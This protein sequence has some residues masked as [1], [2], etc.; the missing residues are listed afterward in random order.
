MNESSNE[1]HTYSIENF[2]TK[3]SPVFFFPFQ[4]TSGS[5]FS[6]PLF[7]LLFLLFCAVV[8]SIAY[9]KIFYNLY[10]YKFSFSLLFTVFALHFCR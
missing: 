6:E 9:M 5:A 4:D 8:H 3:R 2:F 10:D 1:C 7:S